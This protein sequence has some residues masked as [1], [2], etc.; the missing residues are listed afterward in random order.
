M[1]VLVEKAVRYYDATVRCNVEFVQ[2][3]TYKGIDN[4]PVVP[5]ALPAGKHFPSDIMSIQNQIFLSEI[6]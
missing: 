6:I 2:L 1:R 4:T 5:K 3:C